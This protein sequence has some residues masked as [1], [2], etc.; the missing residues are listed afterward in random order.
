MLGHIWH[1]ITEDWRVIQSFKILA[2]LWSSN[3]TV[4]NGS[5]PDMFLYPWIRSVTTHWRFKCEM[6]QSQLLI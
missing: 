2:R 3:T 6:S 1:P 5:A 4:T